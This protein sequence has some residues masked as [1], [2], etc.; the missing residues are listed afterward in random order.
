[1]SAKSVNPWLTMWYRPSEA[2]RYVLEHYPRRLIHTLAI[3]GAF[4]HIANSASFY[5]HS[6]WVTVLI[7]ILLAIITGLITLYIFGGLI[8]WTGNWLHGSASMQQVLSA[9]AWSQ[10]PVLYFFIIQMI[11]LAIMA[12]DTSNVVFASFRFVFTIWGLIIFLACL[13]E[14]QRFSFFKALI[15]YILATIVIAI[16]VIIASLITVFFGSSSGDYTPQTK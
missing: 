5:W 3:L 10:I 13:K 7:W 14:S 9:I 4:T 16:I 15:N 8:K 1:M 11:I 6:W 2:M 12:G